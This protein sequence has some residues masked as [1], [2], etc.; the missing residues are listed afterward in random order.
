MI[1]TISGELL[2]LA[3]ERERE[4]TYLY[5]PLLSQTYRYYSTFSLSQN[6]MFSLKTT[7]LLGEHK[8][9]AFLAHLLYSNCQICRFTSKKTKRVF[10]F[11]TNICIYYL[12]LMAA[13]VVAS[14]CRQS[15]Q[16]RKNFHRASTRWLA[17]DGQIR[18]QCTTVQWPAAVKKTQIIIEQ[19]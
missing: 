11:L 18:T 12:F 17:D 9:V 10:H 13:F 2:L 15:S 3:K 14:R 7:V 4:Q 8:F 1:L 6:F 16:L 5:F 19:N